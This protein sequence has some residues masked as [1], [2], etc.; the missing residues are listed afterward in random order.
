MFSLNTDKTSP[1]SPTEGP[2]RAHSVGEGEVDDLR[3]M[4]ESMREDFSRK[5]A[6]LTSRAE[7]A[8]MRTAQVESELEHAGVATSG[9][10]ITQRNPR[11]AVGGAIGGARPKST[12]Q[13]GP[14]RS[15]LL[16]TSPS[17]RD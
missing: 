13:Y 2:G 10:K 16:Y 4:I 11:G 15:C 8:E 6:N 5:L 1:S 9:S 7:Y 17:P 12:F 14:S 3:S